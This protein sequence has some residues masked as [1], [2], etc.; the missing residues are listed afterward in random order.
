MRSVHRRS[1][2]DIAAAIRN[3]S[4][5]DK[6]SCDTSTIEIGLAAIEAGADFSDGVIAYE[7]AQRGGRFVSFDRKAVEVMTGLG[8]NAMS[9]GI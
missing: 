8:I 5:L 2:K 9:P 1:V 6:V 3:L 7:G 4:E